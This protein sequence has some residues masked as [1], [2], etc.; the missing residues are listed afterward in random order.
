MHLASLP[1][2]W[3]HLLGADSPLHFQS[4]VCLCD[5]S[6]IKGPQSR[7]LRGF[8]QSKPAWGPSPTAW[9]RG[10]GRVQIMPIILGPPKTMSVST[11]KR[12]LIE[13]EAVQPGV[14]R[15]IKP[16]LVSADLPST[17]VTDLGLSE[18][19]AP[20]PCLPL[21]WPLAALIRHFLFKEKNTEEKKI[22]VKCPKTC[23]FRSCL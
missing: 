7:L 22:S 14:L 16:K 10:A 4:P 6:Q 20:L 3:T 19:K 8:H 23:F 18:T 12:S 21:I 11:D 13:R 1:R 15:V 2:G 17:L 9:E 5:P